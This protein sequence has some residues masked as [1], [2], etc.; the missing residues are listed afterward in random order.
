MSTGAG[1]GSFMPILIL[2]ILGI[3]IYSIYKKKK[4]EREANPFLSNRKNKDEVW[5]T[6]KQFLKDKGESGKELADS[7][8]VKRNHQDYINPNGSDFEKKNKN[9]ELK[10]RQWQIK[11]SKKAAKTTGIRPLENPKNRDLFVVVF[12]TKDTKTKKED[13]YRCFE[14]EVVNTKIG[15][16]QYDRKIVIH[17]ELNYDREMEWIAPIRAA[18]EAK[19]K[20]M[21]AKAAKQKE[22]LDKADKKRRIR[23]EKRANKHAKK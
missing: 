4:N 8:V 15:K 22:R 7:Y 16:K 23:Q 6:I 21:E 3:A 2:V 20:A 5:K 17:N 19:N 18:E 9:Y 14:C 12:K 10:I 11:Q 13:P 1:L